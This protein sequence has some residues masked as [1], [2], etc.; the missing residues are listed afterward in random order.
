MLFSFLKGLQRQAFQVPLS[1]Q[2]GEWK[3]LAGLP[4]RSEGFTLRLSQELLAQPA[5]T[6]CK[7][8]SPA[9]IRAAP[10]IPGLSGEVLPLTLS[11]PQFPL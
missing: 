5:V 3:V 11:S 8:W 2:S 6:L 1:Q 10:L 4:T 9:E 7:H